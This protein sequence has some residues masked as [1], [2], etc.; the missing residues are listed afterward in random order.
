[1]YKQIKVLNMRKIALYLCV[2]VFVI[3]GC[4]KQEKQVAAAA[5]ETTDICLDGE[6]LLADLNRDSLSLFVCHEGEITKYGGRGVS[7]LLNL[8]NDESGLLKGSTVADK[9]VGKAAAALMIAG[10]VK[11]VHTN[12]ICTPARQMFEDNDVIINA[13]EE[14]PMI[15]NRTR[16]GQC[17]IDSKLNDAITVEQCVEI[18]QNM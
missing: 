5:T 15:M 10:G 7:D 2:L 11:E 13:K 12:L 9:M 6:S 17:P 16:T 14:V 8:I 1:M 4:K 3:I 18:L